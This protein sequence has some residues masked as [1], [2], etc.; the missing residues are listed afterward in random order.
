[1]SRLGLLSGLAHAAVQLKLQIS[2]F[3]VSSQGRVCSDTGSCSHP[4]EVPA[5]T[6]VATICLD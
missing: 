1:M 2:R 6:K 5:S 3:R 4:T